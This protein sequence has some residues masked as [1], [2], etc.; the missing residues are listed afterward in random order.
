MKD[1]FTIEEVI[2][3]VKGWSGSDSNFQDLSMNEIVAMLNNALV[4]IKCPCD[5]LV[6]FLDR[7]EYYKNNKN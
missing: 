5:G 6:E 2:A 1:R 3:Y 4:S 7:I